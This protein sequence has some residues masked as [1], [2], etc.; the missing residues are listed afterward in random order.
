M[1][2]EEASALEAHFADL[3]G[4]FTRFVSHDTRNL[5]LLDFG[6]GRVGYVSLYR[7][8]FGRAVGIDVVDYARYYDEGI[9]FILSKGRDIPLPDRSVDVIVSH[10]TLEHVED[11][12]FTI[13]ELNR[14]LVEGGYAYLTVAPLYFSQGGGHLRAAPGAGRLTNWEHLDPDS[15]HYRGVD[16]VAARLQRRPQRR[17]LD[18]LNRLT[19]ERFLAAVGAQPWDILTYRIKAQHD[20]PLPGFLRTSA[21]SRVDLYTKEFRLIARKSFSIV[22]DRVLSARPLRRG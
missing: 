22:G 8:H 11:V 4:F 5:T 10:S 3:Y 21:L 2:S 7:E 9:E 18:L 17:Q 1:S 12:G 16:S 15:P 6:C 14:I 20:R 13:G 19:T